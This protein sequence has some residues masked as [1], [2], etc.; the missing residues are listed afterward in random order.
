M[1]ADLAV[2][3]D[4]R[5]AQKQVVRADARDGI[6][7][8]A[9]VDRGVFAENIVVADFQIGGISDVFEVLGFAS[10][11]RKGEKLVGAAE[12]RVALEND[13]RVQDTIIA[14]FDIRSNDA[15]RADTDIASQRRKR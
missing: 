15:K 13:V 12:F 2:V 5:V 1:A 14:E 4:V 3:G 7:V 10:D 9:A 8:G 11:G 6:R